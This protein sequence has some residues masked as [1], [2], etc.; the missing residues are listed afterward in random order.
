MLKVNRRGFLGRALAAGAAGVGGSFVGG[1][2]AKS[3]AASPLLRTP[4]KVGTPRSFTRVDEHETAQREER[5]RKLDDYA[6]LLAGLQAEGYERLTAEGVDGAKGYVGE[7]YKQV[8]VHFGNEDK[9]A[10]L[11]VRWAPS[12]PPD[13]ERWE[14]LEAEGLLR[15][16][17][18]RSGQVHQ[19]DTDITQTFRCDQHCHPHP[20]GGCPETCV[21]DNCLH[22]YAYSNLCRYCS[23]NEACAALCLLCSRL[24]PPYNVECA[25]AC[26]FGCRECDWECCDPIEFFLCPEDVT[27]QLTLVSAA[28]EMHNCW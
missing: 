16:H 17:F 5:A 27:E 18:V 7:G 9:R 6:L 28:P 20:P 11:T 12:S 14:F 1:W 10:F 8:G 24:P 26:Y 23:T 19:S 21:S 22:C 2:A 3:W 4:T 13:V 25:A 15:R